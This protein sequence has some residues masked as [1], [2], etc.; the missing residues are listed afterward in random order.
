MKFL[1]CLFLIIGTAIGTGILALPLVSPE[2]GFYPM[3]LSLVITWSFMTLSAF[4]LLRAVLKHKI[5]D[6]LIT[7]AKINLGDMGRVLAGASYL[8]L[9]YAL[10]SVYILVG[11]SWLEEWTTGI[12]ALNQ[13]QYH[14]IFT[15]I[16][17][18]FIYLGVH[19]VGGINQILASG[20]IITLLLVTIAGLGDIDVVN[21]TSV[22]FKQLQQPMSVMVTAFGFAVILPTLASYT[23]KNPVILKGS[24][25]SASIIIVLLNIMW[26][27]VCFGVIGPHSLLKMSKQNSEGPEIV[28]ALQNILHNSYVGMYAKYFAI[29]ALFSSI[30]GVS[31]SLYHFVI[32][33][34]KLKKTK[35]Y[36]INGI[37][38]T[39]AVPLLALLV[40]PSSF[41][42]ILGF[43]GIFVS[44][45]L[46]I[47]PSM[48]EIKM[49]KDST[50]TSDV[51]LRFLAYISLL[52]YI[53]VIIVELSKNYG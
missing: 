42:A 27:A 41:V 28:L 33:S 23:K 48:L 52:F 14:M 35:Y 32:D 47:I 22:T 43:A 21:F 44:V 2:M 34:F 7:M 4:M 25:M 45:V 51:I 3:L 10:L 17:A 36:K 1:N 6:D 8:L 49:N 9:L 29:F 12:I 39:F 24:L 53:T 40:N 38:L 31:L 19:F 50:A 11:S 5:G 37:V 46:G 18:A 30:I 13:S 26:L 16:C 20:V 15:L